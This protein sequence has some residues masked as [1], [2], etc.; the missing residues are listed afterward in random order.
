MTKVIIEIDILKVNGI[1][2]KELRNTEGFKKGATAI[3]KNMV[4]E[5][6]KHFNKFRMD[7]RAT[8]RIEY[9]DEE[10]NQNG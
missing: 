10:E 1:R 9:G 7:T 8:G 6:P 4:K 3:L 2:E 5:L